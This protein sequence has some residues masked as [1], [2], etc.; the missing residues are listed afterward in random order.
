[1]IGVMASITIWSLSQSHSPPMLA[2]GM[3]SALAGGS[4]ILKWQ[5]SIPG[6]R[7]NPTA[8]L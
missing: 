4:A 8:E 3:L 1:L 7:T 2:L 5:G 6:R